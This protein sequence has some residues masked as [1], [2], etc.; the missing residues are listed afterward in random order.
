MRMLKGDSA[1]STADAIAA[2]I[3]NTPDSP[4]RFVPIA[5]VVTSPV[6]RDTS[7]LANH[8]IPPPEQSSGSITQFVHKLS[9][10]L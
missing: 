1:S 10:M 8:Y 4:V 6:D 7:R 2:G 5:D 9:D 3:G